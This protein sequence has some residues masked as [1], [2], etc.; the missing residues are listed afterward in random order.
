V[1][2]SFLTKLGSK[3]YW[4]TTN[5]SKT[6]EDRALLMFSR[7][8]TA[9]RSKLNKMSDVTTCL[10]GSDGNWE[11]QHNLLPAEVVKRAPESTWN[12]A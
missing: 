10:C 9:L 2:W 1:V 12:E 11:C 6:L 5:E 3:Y 4:F 8:M 7:P